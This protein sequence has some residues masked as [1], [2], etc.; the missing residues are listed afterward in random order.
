MYS[1]EVKNMYKKKIVGVA[2]AAF[3]GVVLVASAGAIYDYEKTNDW[4]SVTASSAGAT[5]TDGSG[6]TA[7]VGGEAGY[8]STSGKI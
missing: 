5:I 1:L 7:P 2:V 4:F 3:F 8:N 6:W